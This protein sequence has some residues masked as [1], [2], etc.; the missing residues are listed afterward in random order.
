LVPETC[1]DPPP[2][3]AWEEPPRD[4][5][6]S[7]L[8]G[9]IVELV[10][11]LLTL[12]AGT[13]AL[14]MLAEGRR[15]SEHGSGTRL[16]Y[17]LS[18][19]A[20]AAMLAAAIGAYIWNRASGI[21]TLFAM[22]TDYGRTAQFGGRPPVFLDAPPLRALKLAHLTDLHVTEGPRVR[23]IEKARPGGNEILPHLFTRPELAESDLI[24]MSG[25]L[26][27]RGT[28]ASWQCFR[29]TLKKYDLA[30]KTILVPGNHDIALVEYIRRTEALRSDRFGV[31]QLANILKF[32]EAFA[33]TYGGTH[34][35]VWDGKERAP[36]LDA[37]RRIEAIARP[38]LEALPTLP[39]PRLRALR[40]RKEIGPFRAYQKRI[41]D[42]RRGLLQLFP[43]AVPLPAHNAEMY[44]VNSSA[45]IFR[46]PT[47]NGFGHVGR[48]Q[49]KRLHRLAE[50]S[51]AHLR[52][53]AVHHHVVRRGEERSLQFKRRFFAKFTVLGDARPLAKFCEKHQVRAVMNGHRHVSYQ[54]R[55][56]NGTVLLAAPSSTMG[57]ELARDPRPQFERYDF[58]ETVAAPSVGVYRKSVRLGMPE[59]DWQSQLYPALPKAK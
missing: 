8:F 23:L 12:A 9:V 55:L 50:S 18:L 15:L 43:V 24:L 22:L 16:L 53:V 36:F 44:V 19:I 58:A 38:L 39:V 2:R 28:A 46:H 47:M 54:L 11:F 17:G 6:G 40:Y 34:G 52:L 29:E 45:R 25:D 13:I 27:D 51:E 3:A 21:A 49:Y 41:E 10:R 33:E 35:F 48:S 56:A 4:G 5:W 7:T 26:T 57:D 14:R 31:V 42:T 59:Q 30:D 32:A 37:F 1:D 20:V